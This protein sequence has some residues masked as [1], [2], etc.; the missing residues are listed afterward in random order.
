MQGK[1]KIQT[2]I[3]QASKQW[4]PEFQSDS[5]P[6]FQEVLEGPLKSIHRLDRTLD[7]SITVPL[8]GGFWHNDAVPTILDGITKIDN[9]WLLIR[10]SPVRTVPLYSALVTG[11]TNI[12]SVRVGATR[13]EAP[14]IT[15]NF[16]S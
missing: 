14:V 4:A 16:L 10:I 1:K 8:G 2:M 13:P 15:S 7:L 3:N 11:I 9:T 12:P 5:G 6:L